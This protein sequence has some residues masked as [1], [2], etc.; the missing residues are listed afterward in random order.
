MGPVLEG[1]QGNEFRRARPAYVARAEA[2]RA[3]GLNLERGIAW[4]VDLGG[5]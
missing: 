2:K 1:L 5:D 4:A 3:N